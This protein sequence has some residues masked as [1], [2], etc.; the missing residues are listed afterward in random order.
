MSDMLFLDELGF[1]TSGVIPILDFI[2]AM[3]KSGRPVEGVPFLFGN[4]DLL[5]L[6]PISFI[7]TVLPI[8]TLYPRHLCIN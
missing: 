5:Q 8:Y 4:E 3:T 7:P 6:E 1:C 2:F